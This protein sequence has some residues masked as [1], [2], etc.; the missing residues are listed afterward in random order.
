[1]NIGNVGAAIGKIKDKDPER[2]NKILTTNSIISG[3]KSN[4]DGAVKDG[5][6]KKP[7]LGIKVISANG[8]YYNLA[9]EEVAAYIAAATPLLGVIVPII[10]G[11][12]DKDA[13]KVDPD[14]PDSPYS[15][16]E[17]QKLID[18]V[19]SSSVYTEEQKKLIVSG[20]N[21]KLDLGTAVSN[22]KAKIPETKKTILRLLLLVRLS[23]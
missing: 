4:L 18:E 2:Y 19:N 13:P 17:R 1:M 21:A 9:G 6:S 14:L 3:T 15:V 10:K 12:T 20:L 22:A 11:F 16:D 5:M 8:E 7:I 23:D